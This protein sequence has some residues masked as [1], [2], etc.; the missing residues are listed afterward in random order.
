MFIFISIIFSLFQNQPKEVNLEDLR[1]KYRVLFYFQE[2]SQE[3][4]TIDSLL[5]YEIQDR[6]LVVFIFQDDVVS[7]SEA[8]SFSKQTIQHIKKQYALN[9][10]GEQVVLIGLDGGVKMRKAGAPE[11]E[12]IF[13][14]IDSMPMRQSEIT[15][16][17]N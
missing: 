11:W 16:R 15:S 14:L 10:K 4:K 6:K 2:D 7:S 8:F 13:G 12:E 5:Q 1:W 3:P 17:N 9:G